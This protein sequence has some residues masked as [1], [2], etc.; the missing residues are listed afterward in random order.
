MVLSDIKLLSGVNEYLEDINMLY[1]YFPNKL[2]ISGKNAFFN[3]YTLSTFYY[4]LEF[5]IHSV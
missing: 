5:S 2:M 1:V 4:R 3:V